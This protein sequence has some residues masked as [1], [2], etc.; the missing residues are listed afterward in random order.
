MKKNNMTRILALVLVLCTITSMVIPLPAFAAEPFSTIEVFGSKD[1]CYITVKDNVPLRASP[2]NKGAV[3]EKLPENYPLMAEGLFRTSKGT[4]WVKVQS[5]EYEEAWIYTGNVELHNCSFLS[6]D[7]YNIKFCSV[8]GHI[9]PLTTNNLV[10]M[11]ALHICLAAASF[12]PVIG[13]GFDMLDALISLA[14]GEYDDAL[15][16]MGAAVPIIGS[17][18]DMLQLVNASVD[19]M[20]A[21]RVVITATR[22]ADDVVE[23]AQKPDY[24]ALKKSMQNKFE[25]TGDIRWLKVDGDEAHHIVPAGDTDPNAAEARNILAYLGIDLN[26]ADNGV[27]LCG[28]TV[29]C[30]SATI[31]GRHGKNYTEA[32]NQRLKKVFNDNK[33]LG[34]DAQRDAIIRELDEIAWALME[35][36]LKLK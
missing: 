1:R 14:E 26:S 8:C 21:S 5:E 27:Y 10:D 24:G 18:P 33:G 19:V 22:M 29:D 36:S 16:A 12:I 32:V 20:K 4:L 3:L 17:I 23:I 28:S 7:D 6:L 31:H 13:N 2:S 34:L 35:G 30:W 25:K 9:V 11:E 15:L